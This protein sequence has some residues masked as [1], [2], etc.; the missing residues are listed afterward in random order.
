MNLVTVVRDPIR[1]LQ[2]KRGVSL[3][4]RRKGEVGKQNLQVDTGENYRS[5]PPY[6]FDGNLLIFILCLKY[7]LLF[8]LNTKTHPHTQKNVRF[9]T[10]VYVCSQDTVL[11]SYSFFVEFNYVDRHSGG[12]PS[13]AEE[14]GPDSSVATQIL[15]VLCGRHIVLCSGT[16]MGWALRPGVCPHWG[17]GRCSQAPVYKRTISRASDDSLGDSD[18]RILRKY[19]WWC[20]AQLRT[21]GVSQQGGSK[22]QG[23]KK[24][25]SWLYVRSTQLTSTNFL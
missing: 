22:C 2:V 21:D 8:N 13:L 16:L 3:Q 19:P 11:K 15:F 25:S 5:F 23:D 4:K 20:W 7:L 1:R 24:T 17:S 10:G 6:W 14:R 12:A 9:Q 18:S